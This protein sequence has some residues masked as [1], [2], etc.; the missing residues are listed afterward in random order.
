MRPRVRLS[1]LSLMS[2]FPSPA[3]LPRRTVAFLIDQAAVLVLVVVPAVLLGVP[4]VRVVA[5]GRTRTLLFLAAMAV[6]FLYH[7]VL[8]WRTGQTLGKR[9]LGLRA[10]HDDGRPLSLGGSFRRNALRLIDGLGY[11]TVAVVVILA[12]GDGK[13]LG[14]VVGRSLVVRE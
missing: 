6:A 8:E 2:T 11:W 13:R 12:R 9:F 10:V 4:A 14:D 5:P 1:S 3:P 7:W